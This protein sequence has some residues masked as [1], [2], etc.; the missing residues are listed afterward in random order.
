MNSIPYG[1]R[2]GSTVIKP[3]FAICVYLLKYTH[4]SL[5]YHRRMFHCGISYLFI[6]FDFR[7]QYLSIWF[8]NNVSIKLFYSVSIFCIYFLFKKIV[9]YST[10]VVRVY[11][12]DFFQNGVRFFLSKYGRR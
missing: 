11:N 2:S 12:N 5:V 6:Y 7:L 3:L 10:C 4:V 8:G 9:Q 1:H